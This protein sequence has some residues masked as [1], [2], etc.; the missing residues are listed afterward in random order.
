MS[1]LAGSAGGG[2][3]GCTSVGS[4]SQ[5]GTGS[6]GTKRAGV[7]TASKKGVLSPPGEQTRTRVAED[8]SGTESKRKFAR[9]FGTEKSYVNELKG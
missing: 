8:D 4:G 3:G 6:E 1:I 7:S 2:I 9:Y 5:R